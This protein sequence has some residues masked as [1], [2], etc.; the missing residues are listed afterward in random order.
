VQGPDRKSSCEDHLQSLNATD[1]AVVSTGA[2]DTRPYT[3]ED[4][5]RTGSSMD[6]SDSGGMAAMLATWEPDERPPLPTW[7]R[8]TI[9]D[10]DHRSW[11]AARYGAFCWPE[12]QVAAITPPTLIIVGSREDPHGEAP[13]WAATLPDGRCKTIS[14]RTHCGT[15]LATAQCL[16]HAAPFLDN[17][18]HGR[19][20]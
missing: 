1:P 4:I 11:M 2:W 10:Y 8:T 19:A 17:A 18:T 12:V 3:L 15:F 20:D 7:F 14:E 16:A 13:A 6:R 9:L 5:R